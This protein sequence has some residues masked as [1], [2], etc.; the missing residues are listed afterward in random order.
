MNYIASIIFT[1][2][3]LMTSGCNSSKEA[4]TDK[5]E[6]DEVVSETNQTKTIEQDMSAELLKQ[7][8]IEGIV[9]YRE[10]SSCPYIIVREETGE[11][12]DPIN[13]ENEKYISFR[14][15][16]EKILF[17]FRRLRMM[18]RCDEA[19]PIELEDVKSMK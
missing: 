3:L 15:N 10:K 14:N 2:L 8:Y 18:N 16:G 12:F 5:G 19:S 13:L 7:G 11:K 9:Q 4:A 1:S 6:T 17:K